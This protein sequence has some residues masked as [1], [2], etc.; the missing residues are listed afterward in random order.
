MCEVSNGCVAPPVLQREPEREEQP[1]DANMPPKFKR[2]LNDEEVTGSIR[3]ERVRHWWRES[4][5]MVSILFTKTFVSPVQTHLSSEL[6][7]RG[8]RFCKRDIAGRRQP[9]SV[10]E[11]L[12]SSAKI[13]E[14]Q[15]HTPLAIPSSL[16]IA[17][18]PLLAPGTTSRSGQSRA[19]T[20]SQMARVEHG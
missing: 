6:K 11:L 13:K 15:T 7:T 5:S 2:H 14:K 4:G 8:E 10:S 20:R 1:D 16:I 18:S 17:P 19:V 12:L 9:Y 3:S